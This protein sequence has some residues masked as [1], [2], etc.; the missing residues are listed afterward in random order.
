MGGGKDKG[1]KRMKEKFEEMTEN[2]KKIE[3]KKEKRRKI[4]KGKKLEASSHKWTG[5]SYLM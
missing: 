5:K 3:R 4:G 2:E 1:G